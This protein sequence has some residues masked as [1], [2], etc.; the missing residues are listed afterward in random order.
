[1]SA[2]NAGTPLLI[3]G[4]KMSRE[5]FI[6]AWENEPNLKCA[7]LI[8]GTVFVSS[9][10]S[11]DH[12]LYESLMVAWLR[13]YS[14]KAPGLM[15]ATNVTS[16]LQESA[17]QPDVSLFRSDV[18]MEARG[19]YP[20]GAPVIAVEVCVSSRDY[21]FGPKKALYQRAGVQEYITVE[22][23]SK[24]ITWR[25][26]V[27]G[28]YENL[29]VDDAGIIRSRALPGLWLDVAAFWRED[30]D[31]LRECVRRGLAEVRGDVG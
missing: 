29:P 17:P 21:D 25:T 4:M 22:T 30:D 12:G 13:A 31:A 7:E 14:S 26:L 1:M 2:I 16:Y 28:S 6:E 23:F 18:G 15:C 10:V 3:T 19:K 27:D 5:E 9:P 24:A 11:L 20:A 8:D